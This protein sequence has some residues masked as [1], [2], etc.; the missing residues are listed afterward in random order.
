MFLKLTFNLFFSFWWVGWPLAP[1][2][3]PLAPPTLHTT[4]YLD[5]MTLV[6]G[7]EVGRLT[8]SQRWNGQSPAKLQQCQLYLELLH[9]MM[10]GH[11]QCFIWTGIFIHQIII[12]H[13]INLP[14]KDVCLSKS[15][16]FTG[17]IL[18]W[19]FREFNNSIFLRGRPPPSGARKGQSS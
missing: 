18:L 11:P 10:F 5:R 17:T 19:F 8:W 16:F 2:S 7:L 1:T 6:P 14:S 3:L 13:T 15:N 4:E 12:L 9:N